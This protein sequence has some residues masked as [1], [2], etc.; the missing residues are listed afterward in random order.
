MLDWYSK[1]V[2]KSCREQQQQEQYWFS[3][4]INSLIQPRKFLSRFFFFDILS[5][6]MVAS[7]I[8]LTVFGIKIKSDH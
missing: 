6:T 4:M 8:V 7:Y 5:L 2:K 3:R 1:N